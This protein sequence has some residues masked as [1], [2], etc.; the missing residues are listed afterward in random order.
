[1]FRA[2]LCSFFYILIWNLP[3]TAASFTKTSDKSSVV[4]VLHLA[5]LVVVR[6]L[7]RG[8]S[9]G[10]SSRSSGLAGRRTGDVGL[11]GSRRRRGRLSRRGR[12]RVLGRG[13]SRGSSRGS[14][15]RGGRSGRGR[16]RRS[17]V[18][19]TAKG[20]SEVN[21][22]EKGRYDLTDG[23]WPERTQPVLSVIAFG[24]VTSL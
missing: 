8:S 5:L 9:G 19:L 13:S 20:V 15:R 3:K 7:A 1:M 4:H 10:L 11:R 2:S 24:Q 21:Q 12:G 22:V 17:G 23:V 16:R 14:L 18:S 6:G